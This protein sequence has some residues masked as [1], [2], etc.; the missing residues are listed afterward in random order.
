MIFPLLWKWLEHSWVYRLHHRLVSPK[1]FWARYATDFLRAAPGERVLDIGCGTADILDH[2]HGVDYTGI[3]YNPDYI[4]AARAR[5]GNRGTFICAAV[6][7]ELAGSH[8]GFDLVIATGL[9]HH[10]DDAEADA[11]FTT[12]R[13]ALRPGGRFITLDGV[14]I[15][16]QNPLERWMVSRDRGRHVRTDDAYHALAQRHFPGAEGRVLRGVTRIP[17]THYLMRCPAEAGAVPR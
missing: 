15:Q 1:A 4:A 16:N 2:L 5:Y 6:T 13:A 3:D 10:L 9:L 12:A 7:P 8:Q 11:L 17:W 14:F